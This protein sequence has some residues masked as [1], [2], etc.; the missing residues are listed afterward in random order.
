MKRYPRHLLHQTYHLYMIA[1]VI[2]LTAC[3]TDSSTKLNQYYVQGEKLYSKHC[4]N[5]HQSDGSGL[6][7]LYPPLNRSDYMDRNFED[8]L[9]LIRFGKSGELIVNGEQF[10]Q[11]M[12]GI[13]TL[14][15]LEIAEIATYI[16]NS[17]THERGIVE[18]KEANNVL[19]N[20]ETGD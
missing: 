8:V 2:A 18:V 17:W 15:D 10:N 20:C 6:G 13:S 4:S 19:S 7:R 1:V 14:S 3:G 16:Y 12:P 11:P 5:C 9:C